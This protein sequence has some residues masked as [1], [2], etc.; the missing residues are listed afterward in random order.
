M[1]KV[2]FVAVVVSIFAFGSLPSGAPQ[3][4]GTYTPV[5]L[6]V[7][8]NA[9]RTRALAEICGDGFGKYDLHRRAGRGQGEHRS[10]RQCHHRLPDHQSED[11]RVGLQVR[12]HPSAPGRRIQPLLQHDWRQRPAG[13]A[14]RRTSIKT[15]CP[16]YDD[17]SGQPQYPAWLLPRLSERVRI[18]GLAA[19]GHANKHNHMGNQADGTPWTRPR[20]ESSAS[21]RKGGSRYTISDFQPAVQDDVD[22]EAV[23]GGSASL[24][25]RSK[26]SPSF[27][28]PSMTRA[29]SIRTVPVCLASRSSV[30][31]SNAAGRTRRLPRP[32]RRARDDEHHIS[33]WRIPVDNASVTTGRRDLDRLR[34]HAVSS[35]ASGLLTMRRRPYGRRQT[36]AKGRRPQADYL[37]GTAACRFQRSPGVSPRGGA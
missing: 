28:H 2:S 17:D 15:S 24:I 30:S 26:P 23:G 7:T 32:P 10:I 20:R 36:A 12:L 16:L 35:E 37:R 8:M 6:I 18:G 22:R 31:G 19:E 9:V 34:A 11:A 1:R 5:P 3:K 33:S 25:V 21:R 27:A 4:P 13:Y 29:R 14:G